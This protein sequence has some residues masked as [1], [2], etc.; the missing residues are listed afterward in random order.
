MIG[1]LILFWMAMAGSIEDRSTIQ[2]SFPGAQKLLVDNIQGSIRVTA[3]PGNEVRVKAEETITAE[4]ADALA[5]AKR[6]VKLDISTQG[7]FARVYVDGPFRGHDR[8]ERFYGY[9]VKFDY[10]IQVPAGTELILKTVNGGE[11]SVKGTNGPFEV[12]NVNGAISMEQIGGS[13]KVRTVNGPLTIAFSRNPTQPSSFHTV[14]GVVDVH[15]QPSLAADLAFRTM[16]GHIYSDFDVAGM[17][18]PAGVTENRNGKFVYRGNRSTMGRAGA[19]GPELSFET[20]NGDI[21]LR[22]KN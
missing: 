7:S 8:G 10:E 14:N 17:P 2:H 5:E 1:T 4:S 20:I 18:A 21:R 3:T 9:R 11:I 19:G 6:D 13:G 22:T 12:S 15:F 16:N